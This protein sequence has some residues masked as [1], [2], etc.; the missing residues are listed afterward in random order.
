MLV[1]EAT[2]L[3]NNDD[4]YTVIQDQTTF[5]YM[6]ST[7]AGWCHNMKMLCALQWLTHWPI[8]NLNEI[9]DM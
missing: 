3:Y 4:Y 1:K 6:S 8:R 5:P 7:P 9:L 2:A